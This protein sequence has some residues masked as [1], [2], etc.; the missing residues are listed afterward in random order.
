METG[1]PNE[2]FLALSDKELLRQCDIHIYK[3]SG[4]GG[5]HRN[6][7]SS[8]VRLLHQP[9]GI[10]SHGDDSRS[11]HENKQLAIQRLRMNIACGLRHS[12]NTKKL[13]IPEVVKDCIFVPKNVDKLS[14]SKKK[15]Q[16]GRKDFRFWQVVSFLLDLLE[17]SKGKIS[18]AAAIVD[19]TTSN[20]YSVF[21]SE[22]HLLSAAQQ[23]RKKFGLTPLK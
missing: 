14:S 13:D 21:Q 1:Q 16:I 23:I 8:A 5:Q 4:P 7:V 18:D 20:L 3:S 11:Q 22:R 15:L 12:I 17:A 19:I 6:K 10:S 9:T 2:D